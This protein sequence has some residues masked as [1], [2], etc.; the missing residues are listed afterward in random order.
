[1]KTHRQVNLS[2][3]DVQRIMFGGKVAVIHDCWLLLVLFWYES[4]GEHF[5]VCADTKLSVTNARIDH[6][7]WGQMRMLCF[8]EQGVCVQTFSAEDDE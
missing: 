1:M 5:C 2:R 4:G 7:D 6:L 3:R 8:D